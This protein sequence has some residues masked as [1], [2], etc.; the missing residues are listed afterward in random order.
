MNTDVQIK[1]FKLDELKPAS[2]NPRV[3]TEKG[4]KHLSA[5]LERFGYV[6]PI[7][8]NERTG[9]IVGGHQRFSV[10]ARQGVNEVDCVALSLSDQEEMALNVT[11]NKTGEHFEWDV[12]KLQALLSDMDDDQFVSMGFDEVDVADFDASEF[13]GIT[14]KLEEE[15]GARP[16]EFLSCPHCGAHCRR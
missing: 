16:D 2:Y 3:T 8:V 11:L 1:R 15:M 14:S 9:R 7:I 13:L 10:L 6:D 4:I 12:P 5:S